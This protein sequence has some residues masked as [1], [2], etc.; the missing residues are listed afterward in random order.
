MI[1]PIV[2]DQRPLRVRK[3]N[4]MTDKPPKRVLYCP[5][6]LHNTF[7]L[8]AVT[9]LKNGRVDYTY[10]E[11]KCSHCYAIYDTY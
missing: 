2:V 1:V 9:P 6:C 7:F 4:V 5:Y 10:T 8:Y 11:A 3:V